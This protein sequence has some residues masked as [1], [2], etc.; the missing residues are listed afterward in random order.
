VNKNYFKAVTF[1]VFL[2]NGL[3]DA[4][5]LSGVFQVTMVRFLCLVVLLW[6]FLL[7]GC[8][9]VQRKEAVLPFALP[10]TF[11]SGGQALIPDR[12]WLSFN[13]PGL[14]SV[15]EQGISDN[16]SIRTVWDRLRQAEQTAIIAGADLYPQVDYSGA[17]GRE[18]SRTGGTGEYTN[19]FRLGIGAAYE[20]D[21]W[22]R[23]KSLQQAALMDAEAAYE[24]VD[25]AA[26][27]LSAAIAQTWY[28]LGEA[29]LQEQLIT[30]Q[31]DANEK[32]LTIIR[33]QFRQGQI[34]AANVFRQEQLVEGTRGQIILVQNEIVLLQ[35]QL[36]V[37][38]GRQPKLWWADEPIPLTALPD[39]PDV[40]VPS[41]LLQRRPDLRLAQKVVL[42]ADY[43]A[44]AAVAE[45]Y[46]RFSLTAA[47]QTSAERIG[48]LF[49][50]WYANLSVNVLG[51]LFD[52]GVR[53]ANVERSRAVL[54]QAINQYG[55]DMLTAMKE[56]EDAL[57]REFLQRQY[58]QS[59][60]RQLHLAQRTYERTR[61][62]YL[63]GQ[64]DYIRV[65]ESQV[66][67][68]ALERSELTAR[69]QLIEYRIDLCRSLAGGW[70]MERPARAELQPDQSLIKDRINEAG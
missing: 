16:F 19:R 62:S 29:K 38:L 18:Y 15:M 50:D 54:S 39:L 22:G 5:L 31:L 48:D 68:Q 14:N 61:E 67:M 41:Q 36:S 70:S 20:V 7:Q 52:A 33:L 3:S 37:L 30:S 53:K 17:A 6:S 44:G 24:R 46:P 32:M 9:S 23:V 43:R 40:G 2:L 4:N 11:S 47:P 65:L 10:E 35:H 12:W 51:P 21:L 42:A 66:S 27:S 69:R 28:R 25:A 26:I 13:D 63:K 64:L 57:S 45:Q 1:Q 60:H 59:L 49:D 34:G 58:L 56:V 55:Q 8:R